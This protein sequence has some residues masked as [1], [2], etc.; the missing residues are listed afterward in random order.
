[1]KR[2]IDLKRSSINSAIALLLILGCNGIAAQSWTKKLT[3]SEN[4]QSV[5][6]I[7]ASNHDLISVNNTYYNNGSDHYNIVV[8]RLP[9]D[10]GETN[11]P[12]ASNTIVWRKEYHF[13][14]FQKAKNFIVDRSGNIVIVGSCVTGGDN[15]GF[16]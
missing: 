6:V 15:V 9:S 4:D 14:T 2:L 16:I 13:S 11:P 12:G 1:M 5:G 8:T 7:E 10:G 3:L